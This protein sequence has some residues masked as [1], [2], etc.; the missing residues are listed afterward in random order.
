[1]RRYVAAIALALSTSGCIAFPFGLPPTTMSVGTGVRVTEGQSAAPPISF[2]AGVNPL[3]LSKTAAFRNFDAGFGYLY[4]GSPGQKVHGAYLEAGHVI[5][6]SRTGERSA[7][8]IFAMGQLR[9]LYDP[10]SPVLGRGA[11]LRF[12]LETTSYASAALAEVDRNGGVFG[13]AEG[14]GAIGFYA[15]A[16]TSYV[17]NKYSYAFTGG[18]TVRLP[19]VV[20]IAFAWAWA[21]LTK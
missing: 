13:W 21:F 3:G 20:G 5:A 15:E 7:N 9:M 6:R 11:A 8:R 2:R 14:E 17:A 16:D 1:M 18:L 10:T 19:S 12:V 4:Q